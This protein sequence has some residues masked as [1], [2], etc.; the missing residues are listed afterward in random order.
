DLARDL[1]ARTALIHLPLDTVTSSAMDD[2]KSA[3][4]VSVESIPGNEMGLDIGPET[5]ARYSEV[6]KS[7]RTIVW[8]GPMGVFEKD[9]F[10]AGKPGTA[11]S[12]AD[13]GAISRLA[14]G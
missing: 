12:V 2:E 6:I 14:A 9:A 1:L 10:A 11:S 7:S 8:N 5:V 3:H 4:V 13:W